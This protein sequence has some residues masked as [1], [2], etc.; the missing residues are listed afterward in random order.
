MIFDYIFAP[1][2]SA[3]HP[4]C[5]MFSAAHLIAL[6]I[7]LALVA[8]GVFLCR[9]IERKQLKTLTK[10]VAVVV[11]VL[12]LTKIGYNFYYGYTWI[13][14]WVPLAFCSLFIYA[15][16]LA[17]FG[18]GFLEKLGV[19][20]MVGGCITAG[21]LFLIFP[22][23]S[24]QM[25][26]IYHFL[27]IYSMLFHGLMVWLGILHIFQGGYRPTV[28]TFAYYA[29]FFACFALVSLIINATCSA[30]LMFLDHPFNIP[31]DF[32]NKIYEFSSVLYSIL[33]FIAYLA[34]FLVSF[35]VHS[36]VN[37]I[38]LKFPKNHNK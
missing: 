25:H 27:C 9:N 32:I 28:K 15:C 35:G 20:F 2:D 11:T 29:G 16:W 12:E 19:G 31:L 1:R 18:K 38:K 23:T 14:A 36:L 37:F 17:G 8:L 22:T 30:N 33:I 26:P 34:C 5:G 10:I 7:T 4:A 24:L 6:F 3:E 13:D 21:F